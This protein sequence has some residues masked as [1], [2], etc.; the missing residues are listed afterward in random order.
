[1]AFNKDD[2]EP[3]EDIIRNKFK[4]KPIPF[5]KSR[6]MANPVK[7]LNLDLNDTFQ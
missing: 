2:N 5:T 7:Y 6:G 1:L 4:D 3:I